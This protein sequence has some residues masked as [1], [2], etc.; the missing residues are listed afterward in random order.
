MSDVQVLFASFTKIPYFNNEVDST[1][2][3]K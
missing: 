3:L 2:F 1:R